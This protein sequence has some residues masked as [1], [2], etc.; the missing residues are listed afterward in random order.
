MAD[1]TIRGKTAELLGILNT[2]VRINALAV[3]STTFVKQEMRDKRNI[4]CCR[5][6]NSSARR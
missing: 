6:M 2:S 3:A 1:L 5:A 4:G